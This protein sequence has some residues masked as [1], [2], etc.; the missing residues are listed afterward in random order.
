ML[1]R[2]HCERQIEPEILAGRRARQVLIRIGGAVV[3]FA[4]QTD[5]DVHLIV[6]VA[7]NEQTGADAMMI[8]PG[9]VVPVVPRSW[10]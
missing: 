8:P 10:R 9:C 3:G 7:G 5:G 4:G 2:A 1:L 6:D